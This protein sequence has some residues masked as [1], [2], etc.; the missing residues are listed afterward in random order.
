MKPNTLPT[1]I[2][3]CQ[4][5]FSYTDS[6]LHVP[7]GPMHARE[8]G[9]GDGGTK[10]LPVV[11]GR[12]ATRLPLPGR[13][14]GPIPPLLLGTGTRPPSFSGTGPDPAV[15]GSPAVPHAPVTS[16]AALSSVSSGW[17]PAPLSTQQYPMRI[18]VSA[19][20]ALVYNTD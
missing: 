6:E 18:L 3:I 4:Y 12:L 11:H 14:P 1:M 13:S 15:R 10:G 19:V 7:W 20:L 16:R 17:A 2:S 8:T 5:D 9:G